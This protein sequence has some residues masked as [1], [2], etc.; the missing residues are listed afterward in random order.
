ML[1]S[2]IRSR[3][4]KLAQDLNNKEEMDEM[5]KKGKIFVKENFLWEKITDDFLK[6]LKS[7]RI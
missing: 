7:M 3:T 6:L 2:D 4:I 1:L 5:G